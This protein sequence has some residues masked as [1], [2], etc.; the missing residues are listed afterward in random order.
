MKIIKK[1]MTN[2]DCYKEN[3]PMTPKG[4]MLH[5]VG[6]PQPDPLVF[7][8]NQNKPNVWVAVHAYIGA[9][10]T[11]YQYLPW[12]I[13]GWHA[14]GAAN[15]THIGVEMTEPD[16]I[17]YT[18]GATFTCSDKAAAIAHAEKTYKTAVELFAFLCKEYGLNPL[19]DIIGHAEGYKKGVA[20]NHADPEHM[21]KQLGMPYSMDTFRADVKKLL[22]ESPQTSTS[23]TTGMTYRVRKSWEDAKSQLGAFKKLE[24]AKNLADKNK[25]YYVFDDSGKAIY[26]QNVLNVGDKV[27][28]KPE[29]TVYNKKTKFSSW[30]YKTKLYVRQINGDRIVVSTVKTGPITGSVHK[31]HLTKI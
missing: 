6:C 8:N 21:W 17:K 22:S 27:M 23:S 13:K 3:E 18:H 29:A 7:W 31:K 12:N 28:L 9:E 26:P 25:G 1:F 14:G 16:C 11:V 5:S 2:N 15:A 20:S 24:Y 30:V 10:D 4:L 19:T